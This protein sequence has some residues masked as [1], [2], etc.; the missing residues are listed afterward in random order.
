MKQTD[1]KQKNNNRQIFII[2]LMLL[3]VPVA[4]TPQV[5]IGSEIKPKTGALLDLKEKQE[6]SELTNATRGL[7]LPRVHLTIIDRLYPMF[8]TSPGSGIA[9]TNYDNPQKKD[10]MDVVH[11]G[12]TVYNMNEC[13]G[14]GVMTW[15]GSR[16]VNLGLYGDV[17]VVDVVAMQNNITVD[18]D[19]TFTLSVTTSGGNTYSYE[20]EYS[21]DNGSV[22]NAV[23]P[24]VNNATLTHTQNAG[25]RYIYR[26]VV[27][28]AC[29][30]LTCGIPSEEIVVNVSDFIESYTGASVC[31]SGSVTL[32]ATATVGAIIR[33]YDALTGGNKLAE[34]NSFVTPSISATTDY[35]IEA[36]NSNTNVVSSP[37]IKVTATVN[38]L[39]EITGTTTTAGCGTIFLEATATPGAVINWYTV[40]TGGTSV[41]AG[42]NHTVN[43]SGT[44]Y[45]EAYNSD[46]QCY[47]ASRT[48]VTATIAALPTITSVTSA[49]GC[50]SVTLQAVASSGD[51][52]RW[53]SASS[54][55]SP[56]ATGNTY[57]VST[58]ST[59]YV[60]AYN[61]TTQCNSLSRTAV[62]ATIYATP[63]ITS[64]SS[65]IGT[66]CAS[67]TATATASSGASVRWYSALSGGTLLGEGKTLTISGSYTIVYAEA[68]IPNTNCVSSRTAVTGITR[69][70]SASFTFEKPTSWGSK[71]WGIVR[72]PEGLCYT[73]RLKDVRNLT[74][75][76]TWL[77]P[78]SG[79]FSNVD[80]KCNVWMIGS[81]TDSFPA[82]YESYSWDVYAIVDG[83]EIKIGE[84][85]L[86]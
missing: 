60:E 72:G 80:G 4:V 82:F 76:V 74:W 78:G 86:W 73:I 45:A 21:T 69:V 1:T 81:Q 75:N 43:T 17:C 15:T 57:T 56:I 6:D 61:S 3:Q 67:P 18:V 23:I 8:E 28:A 53:Y 22:W 51:V 85:V 39:P 47:S 42:D 32:S 65:T 37:R 14:T 64:T 41:K 83:C 27:K 19:E 16:W 52:V 25:G 7:M 29:L 40:P 9:N 49:A 31:G 58:S 84:T 62:T 68:Y 26:C 36:Y 10:D 46:T 70:T 50:G 24:A 34:G 30:P 59:Y 54:G 11:V 44:Y 48:A 79:A 5:T 35:Y 13:L 33:W 2:F 77:E 38:S 55:G 71:K 66:P 12:L 63:T 20:W